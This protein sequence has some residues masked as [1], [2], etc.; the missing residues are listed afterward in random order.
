[1][2]YLF[3]SWYEKKLYA[4][5]PCW[6]CFYDVHSVVRQTEKAVLCKVG[7]SGGHIRDVNYEL[8][9][10]G[11]LEEQEIE[12][13]IP[14]SAFAFAD[15]DGFQKKDEKEIKKYIKS[16]KSILHDE[17]YE[18]YVNEIKGLLN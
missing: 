5:D 10:K 8:E 7:V 13:W 15:F 9:T 1:M 16:L 14:K 17:D 3:A 4:G 6:I 2:K 18:P 11:K 12:K